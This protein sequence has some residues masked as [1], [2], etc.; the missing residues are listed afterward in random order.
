MPSIPASLRTRA[1]NL[2]PRSCPSSPGLAMRTRMRRPGPGRAVMLHH[3]VLAVLAEDDAQLVADLAEGRLPV[4]GID[5]Q[6][7]EVVAGGGGAAEPGERRAHV[8]LVAPG[9]EA[10][11]SLHL[12][13]LERRV[14]AQDGDRRTGVVAVPVD[15]DHDA[16]ARVDLALQLVRRLLDLLLHPA[17]LDGAHHAAQGVDAR[18]DLRRL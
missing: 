10:A 9:A 4:D 3:H 17:R 18:Q 7:H 12:L 15:T 16:L 14:D 8:L 1:M 5:D 6:G 11:Q 13:A 2:A